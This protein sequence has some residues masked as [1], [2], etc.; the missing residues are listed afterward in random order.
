MGF[1]DDNNPNLFY[2]PSY[3]LES[4]YL[5]DGPTEEMCDKMKDYIDWFEDD[6]DDCDSNAPEC[7]DDEVCFENKCLKID[8]C[9]TTCGEY[10]DCNCCGYYQ[11]KIEC[12]TQTDCGAVDCIDGT[13][14][15]DEPKIAG[16]FELIYNGEGAINNIN[17]EPQ[18]TT[19]MGIEA[20][21]YSSRGFPKKQYAI[22]LQNSEKIFPQCD[23]DSASFNLFCNGF[24]P[25]EGEDYGDECIFNKQND[26]V[27]LG[28]F[29]DRTYMRNAITYEMWDRMDNIGSNSKYI[30]LV[31]N[32]V[33]MGLYVMF[34]KPKIDEHR[35]PIEEE[36]LDNHSVDNNFDGGWVVKVESG[37]EQDYF[38]GYDS[39]TK[40]EYYDPSLEFEDD[41][42]DEEI[43]EVSSA[44]QIIED[45]VKEFEMRV[46]DDF[47]LT[48][49]EE[50]AHIPDF[51]DYWLI[52]EFARNNE[53]FTRSQYWHSFGNY[54]P[55][56][57]ITLATGVPDL[58]IT[59][60]T[61]CAPNFNEWVGFDNNKI[62]I[63]YVWDMNHSFAATIINPDGWAVQNFFAVPQVWVNLF[64]SS[65]FQGE[66]Y[67]RYTQLKDEIPIFNVSEINKLINKFSNELLEYN[68]VNR[69]QKRWYDG[70]IGDFNIYLKNFR[71]YILQRIS[72]MDIHICQEGISSDVD[73]TI[74]NETEL[75]FTT[76]PND[77]KNSNFLAIYNPYEG[78]IFDIDEIGNE[79]EIEMIVSLNLIQ[80]L[81]DIVITIT[82][83]STQII[84]HTFTGIEIDDS[85]YVNL[86]W[87]TYDRRIS[88]KLLGDYTIEATL[89]YLDLE[90]N[91]K[92]FSIRNIGKTNGCT[93]TSAVNFDMFAIQDDGSCKYQQQCNEKY[94]VSE[95]ITDVI[96][97]YPGY[98]TISY[99][100]DF[101]GVDV[102]LFPVLTNSYYNDDGVR[103]TFEENDYITAFFDDV[104]YTATY[105]GGEW[106]PSIN[107]GFSLNEL[108][109]G[110]GFI[111]YVSKGGRIIW[112]IPKGELS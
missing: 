37:A 44:R 33:Y 107:R 2:C 23:D 80:Y 72:W 10:S 24:S 74:F 88:G 18:L 98:N 97:L 100:L 38:I 15:Q 90:E 66:I 21:G 53:G 75:Q 28:P 64:K 81:E 62:Y 67:S 25:E 58:S 59:N 111:L 17:D 108:S 11:T 4:E 85:G 83:A 78:Q 27:L 99:P 82:D 65:W 104:V 94:N 16:F 9:C 49:V 101:T 84:V 6:Y 8:D 47:D 19:R 12:Q 69:D 112:D 103:D 3:I 89:L 106:I 22:E 45:T 32:D 71:K 86:T 102:D 30:E 26:F 95:F 110:I 7:K 63:S 1:V 54:A 68:A 35:V 29:R 43:A 96:Y 51:V 77:D 34:E 42:E 109:K 31:L 36:I 14:I 48:A 56:K 50:V 39:Y 40:Y 79:F 105:M 41:A 13:N 20:R 5:A 57:C 93:D 87:D 73:N 55:G 91:I 61:E 76:C 92:N 46:I 70:E 52:Q 60:Q